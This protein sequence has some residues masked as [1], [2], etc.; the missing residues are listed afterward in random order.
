MSRIEAILAMLV[1]LLIVLVLVLPLI[2]SITDYE[3][4]FG[5]YTPQTDLDQVID[6]W[7]TP[8]LWPTPSG[9]QAPLAPQ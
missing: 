1:V 2:I 4:E 8:D 7:E 6:N 9:Y 3:D 5:S